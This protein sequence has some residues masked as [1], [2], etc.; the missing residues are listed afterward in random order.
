MEV[1]GKQS[2]QYFPKDKHFLPTDTHTWWAHVI[3]FG[4][5]WRA[6][7]S[8]YLRFEIRPFALLPIKY[9]WMTKCLFLRC[10]CR[11]SLKT[12]LYIGFA[13]CK[14][15]SL[16]TTCIK[17]NIN[18]RN[19]PSKFAKSFNFNETVEPCPLIIQ[20]IKGRMSQLLF[21]PMLRFMYFSLTFLVRHEKLFIG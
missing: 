4:T 21:C 15:L 7:F 9:R 3:V 19:V 12:P 11:Q 1:I 18:N 5:F 14:W 17:V 8:F 20:L 13:Q 16:L 2:I 6:L 10:T